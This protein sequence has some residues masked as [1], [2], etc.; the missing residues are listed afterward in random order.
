MDAATIC[1]KCIVVWLFVLVP[2]FIYFILEMHFFVEK[3][4]FFGSNIKIRILVD[5]LNSGLSL[6]SSRTKKVKW[7]KKLIKLYIKGPI[8]NK[9]SQN[10]I[11]NLQIKGRCQKHPE[12]GV[13]YGAAFGR[14]YDPPHFLG[15]PSTLPHF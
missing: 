11:K 5:S 14:N 6:N 9:I 8:G 4:L 15:Y 7:G 1:F 3:C 12:G 13:E 2:F 10:H